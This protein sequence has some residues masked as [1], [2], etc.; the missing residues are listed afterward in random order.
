MDVYSQ[1]WQSQVDL[2]D[3]LQPYCRRV[4]FR[5]FIGDGGR[6]G[7][8]IGPLQRFDCRY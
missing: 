1:R 5:D 7:R 3:F 6:A 8:K 2:R 4:G